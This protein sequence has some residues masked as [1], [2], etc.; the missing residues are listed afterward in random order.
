MAV[1]TIQ[2][3]VAALYVAVF[4]RAPDAA[5]LN[6]WTAVITSGQQTFAQVAAGFAAHEVF[7]TGIGTLSNTDF[8]AALYQNI[9]GSAGD[10]GGIA[11]WSNQLNA[12]MSKADV[13]ALFVQAA[14]TVDIPAMLAAGSLT[15]AE[16]AA[17]T[18]RQQTLTNKADVGIY[19]A[20]TLGAASNL[21]PNTV[22]SSKAG[23]EADPIYNASKAAIANV[24]DSLASVAAAK[25]AIAVAAGSSNPAQA[26]LGGTFT[27]TKGLDT[28]TGTSGNDTIIASV[29]STVGS[30]L[31]TM[32]P[33]DSIN[34]GA[35]TDTLKIAA[36]T[37]LTTASLAN[38]SNVEIIQVDAV[39]AVTLD[40]SAVAGVTNLN[41][42]KAGGA[43]D[44][45]AA[46]T[47]DIN[48]SLKDAGT[49]DVA[50]GKNVTVKLT[51][52]VSAVN[53]GVGAAADATG[54]VVVEKTAAAAANGVNV[55]TTGAVNVTGGTTI[56]VTQKAG[57]A[58]ALVV[59]GTTATHTQGNVTVIGNAATTAVT[60]K[61][62]AAVTAVSGAA[63]VAGVSEVASVKFG[64][65][66]NGATLVSNGLTFTASKALTAA[67]VAATF[68]NLTKDFAPLT[69]DT[70]GSGVV[71]NGTYTGAFTGWT[72]GAVN[73]DTVIFTSTALPTAATVTDL[74]FTGTGTATVTTTTQSVQAVTGVAAKLGVVA[75][76]V[77]ITDS[78]ALKT[79]TVDGYS[80][81]GSAITGT[82]G[83]LESLT[84]KNGG[85]FTVADTA[86][87][88]ALSLEKITAASAL[89]FTAA[90]KTLNV[91]SIGDNQAHLVMA[92]TETLNVSGTGTLQTEIGMTVGALKTVKVTETAGLTLDTNQAGT[93]TTVDTTGTTGAVSVSIN[94]AQATYTGG[95]GKDTVTLATGTALTKAIN[96]GAG[97][98]TLVFGAAVTGS[99][100]ALAGGDGIDTLSMTVANADALDAVKQ[101]FYTG[102]ERLTL[103]NAYN[104]AS[105]DATV[106][107]LTINLENL[108]FTNYVTTSGTG[109]GSG[110]GTLQDILVL[111]KMASNGTVVL[112]ANGLV[113]VGVTDAATGTAD[114]LNAVLSSTGN[115]TAG[116]L[117]AANV[118][119]INISTV[120]TEVVVAPAVQTKNV[121]TLTLTADKATT[122]NVTGAADLTLTLTGSTKVTSID[123]STMT[124]GL[125]VTSLNTTAATTIKGG[126]GNDV[127][128][129]ATGNTADVLIGGAGNDTLVANAGMS[130]LT[131]GAGND[132]FVIG[133]E[134]ANVNSYA[135]ITD[136]A[137]GDLL[138]MTGIDSFAAAK[139]SLGDTAVFQD[140]ANAALNALSA[141]AGGWFQFSGNT[142][143]VADKGTDSTSGFV[144]G[145]DFIVKMTGLVD[146]SNASFNNTSDTIAL[147]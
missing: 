145:E 30:E 19:F 130:T 2:Q 41:I 50:G 147:A 16:A 20:N 142:Y 94:G 113:T 58:S 4:N 1:V 127:L 105:I 99:T 5:G 34:G 84:L 24:T 32:S 64:A 143:V 117:T 80:A 73:G 112:T 137:A 107:S 10:A 21:N 29:D 83:A 56:N 27:L 121:D 15:A 31:N 89:T 135:T 67:E 13:A 28:V 140:Y 114:V 82:A 90:P 69:G 102:F 49:V 18:V 52:A 44:A 55:A 79:V 35:G 62:D 96:L 124:G 104:G 14:L 43:V 54:A 48:V 120:D 128:T 81:A 136:F 42:A 88:L 70:Q 63:A 40:T 23:L 93:L 77:T 65:M 53:V 123:G 134:S 60:V 111:D 129:A 100:A 57:D 22:S 17:A 103:N 97:D 108:G 71:A 6:A 133:T 101:T 38:I 51:D 119:T 141:N 7:T 115:L 92:A 85:A 86:D 144:N 3:S 139:V 106:D 61:Q 37:A 59:G 138:Q 12:G 126:A 146:L 39:N 26:L 78:A 66:A 98:D 110:A 125:T 116:T 122:V 36:A 75:G 8:V 9:L 74:V 87:T 47:T 25:D 11:N 46:N 95:A 118:E 33:I 45:T 76:T 72:S 132:L 68:A 109:V 131:G 91:N